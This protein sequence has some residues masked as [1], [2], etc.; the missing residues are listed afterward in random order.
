MKR[1]TI[2]ILFIFYFIFY[3]LYKCVHCALN[4]MQH[5]IGSTS[6]A[7]QGAIKAV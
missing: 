5:D 7:H 3:V 4:I 1:K 2:A 6:I